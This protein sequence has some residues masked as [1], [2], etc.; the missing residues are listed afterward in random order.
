MLGRGEEREGLRERREGK[1]R[2]ACKVNN[3]LNNK[4]I[5]KLILLLEALQ[6]WLLCH[7]Y[8]NRWQRGKRSCLCSV[9]T[10]EHL[11]DQWPNIP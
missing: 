11:N 3:N 2:S 6:I 4:K 7:I 9:L 8:M 1:L 5:E 10:C